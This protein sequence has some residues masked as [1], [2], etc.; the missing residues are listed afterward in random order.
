MK[1]KSSF[2]IMSICFS[3]TCGICRTYLL[4]ILVDMTHFGIF[5]RSLTARYRVTVRGNYQY[6]LSI[7]GSL[8]N[9]EVK[10]GTVAVSSAHTE[11]HVLNE[12]HRIFENDDTSNATF[13]GE[14]LRPWGNL[15][16]PP[17]EFRL[18]CCTFESKHI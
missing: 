9:S 14:G 6:D 7:E 13:P 5:V 15:P 16:K 3:S 8:L 10:L 1:S 4:F 18:W 12:D 17:L 11:C 2:K